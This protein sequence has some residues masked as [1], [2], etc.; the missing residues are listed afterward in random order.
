MKMSQSQIATLWVA[1]GGDPA[2]ADEWS[3][4]SMAESGGDTKAGN[5]CCHGIAQLNVEVGVSTLQCAV[6]PVCATRT[7]IRL[8]K[9]GKD[10]TPWEAFTNGA[11]KQFLGK[12]G[13][14]S[15]SDKGGGCEPASLGTI[16]AGAASGAAAGALLPIPGVDLLSA[17]G[18]AVVGGTAAYIGGNVIG[19]CSP[20]TNPLDGIDALAA[21]VEAIARLI[22]NM[23]TAHFWV[24]FGK[25]LLGALLIVY[26]LQGMLK[27]VFGME[28]PIGPANAF[29]K[30]KGLKPPIPEG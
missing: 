23:F 1:E 28:L 29:L 3:A 9:N 25:G 27:S 5:S 19:G 10:W 13:K 21:A 17:A 24:R 7:S 20:I 11:Y 8:S 14:H 16:G 2:K 12:S 22:E 18:G 15:Q 4:I 26:A 30:S 6:S